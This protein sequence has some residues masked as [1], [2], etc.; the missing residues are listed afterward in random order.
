MFKVSQLVLIPEDWFSLN[1]HLPV[2]IYLRVVPYKNI[3]ILVCM[4]TGVIVQIIFRQLYLK[5][6]GASFRHIERTVLLTSLFF[7]CYNPSNSLLSCFWGIDVV[8]YV[9]IK[10][11]VLK[12]G[13]PWILT[14]CYFL[15]WYLFHAKTSWWAMKHT[16]IFK[17]KY[18][19]GSCTG[20]GTWQ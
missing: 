3:S 11:K 5:F 19:I 13:N 6:N 1:N 16:C 14:R 18:E 7:D 9:P 2:D 20:L 8:L 17:Y 4:S 12:S 10:V 15:C